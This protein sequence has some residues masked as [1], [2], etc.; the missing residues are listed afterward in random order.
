[1]VYLPTAYTA[2]YIYIH[3]MQSPTYLLYNADKH[4]DAGDGVA[5]DR[6]NATAR[7]RGLEKK[8]KNAE[9]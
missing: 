6:R 9:Q 4:K 8:E 5:P 1:M 3:N 2:V 7:R